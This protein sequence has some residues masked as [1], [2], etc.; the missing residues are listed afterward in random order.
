MGNLPLTLTVFT[1]KKMITKPS[2]R[3]NNCRLVLS[4]RHDLW[5]TLIL[6]GDLFPPESP[7]PAL[8]GGQRN[9]LSQLALFSYLGL[10][11]SF[12]P[13]DLFF[14]GKTLCEMSP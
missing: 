10:F 8:C 2:L 7:S 12:S 13:L 3:A 1:G 6:L 11:A 5:C 9:Y 14:M 4:A